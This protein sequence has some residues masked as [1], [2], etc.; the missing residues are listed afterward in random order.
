MNNRPFGATAL[1]RKWAHM[2][3]GKN[4]SPMTSVEFEP[5]ISGTDHL[6]F[7]NWATGPDG[8]NQCCRS[9][10]GPFLYSTSNYH[11]L[12][13]I[14]L[15]LSVERPNLIGY[16]LSQRSMFSYSLYLAQLYKHELHE[17]HRLGYYGYLVNLVLFGESI[18]RDKHIVDQSHNIH[19]RHSWAD[20]SETVKVRKHYRHT[21]EKL[22]HNPFWLRKTY[23][24]ISFAEKI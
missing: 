7:T 13:T 9:T 6:C 11:I 22:K 1:E 4:L 3:E 23:Y 19:G 20:T 12:I 17:L 16:H 14:S 15:Y 10:C 24:P 2:E 21:V 8:S 18:K 5:T